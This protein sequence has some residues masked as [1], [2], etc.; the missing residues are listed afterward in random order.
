M[1][2]PI[3]DN[4]PARLV[5]L[6]NYHLLDS[7]RESSFDDFTAFAS[8]ICQTPIALVSLVDVD[9]QWFK[10]KVGLE[11]DQTPRDVAFCSHAIMGKDLF[12]VPDA[13]RDQ[14]FVDNPLVTGDPSI[15]FYAGAPLVDRDGFGLGTLCVIDRVPRS[16]DPKQA[17]ALRA[18]ARQ[19]MTLIE[20]RRVLE[21]LATALEEVKVLEGMI[22]VCS[23]CKNV[24]NDAG[25]WETIE[26]YVTSRTESRFTHGI[27][28][29]CVRSLYPEIADSVLSRK[30]DT[31]A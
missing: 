15:R 5:A 17:E 27:C 10:S 24:R 12:V 18:L 3:P 1:N 30:P 4:E 22:P 6:R 19:V 14:R 8:H 11:V 31:S 28:P 26:A 7:G 16:L 21:R 23:S 25:F 29:S 13:V 9:R 20:N 2:Q